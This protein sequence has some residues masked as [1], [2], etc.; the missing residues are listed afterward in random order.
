MNT[1][2]LS[3]L[4][5][6][7]VLFPEMM[8]PLRILED[9]YKQMIQACL[10]GDLTFGVALI[11]SGQEVG[12]PVEPYPVGTTARI[13]EWVQL[14]KGEFNLLAL[15]GQRFRILAILTREPFLQVWVEFLKDA[16]SD[17]EALRPLIVEVSEQARRYLGMLLQSEKPLPRLNLPEDPER[18]SYTVASALQIP[19]WERQELLELMDTRARLE[20]LQVVLAREIQTLQEKNAEQAEID[21][22]RGGNGRLRTEWLRRVEWWFRRENE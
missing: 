20:R 18:L 22:I 12:G 19:A 15:G 2:K 4:P 5:L 3:L 11:K 13:E 1:R 9:R 16:P 7:A 17:P 21:R 10:E 14:E 6:N 8:L